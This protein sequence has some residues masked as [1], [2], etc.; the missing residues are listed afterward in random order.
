VPF[1]STPRRITV[2]VVD[3][4]YINILAVDYPNKNHRRWKPKTGQKL[5]AL[6][7]GAGVK[8]L[9]NQ[10]RS[11]PAAALTYEDVAYSAIKKSSSLQT[12]CKQLFADWGAILNTIAQAFESGG[13]KYSRE[14]TFHTQPLRKDSLPAGACARC[15]SELFFE[16]REKLQC[17]EC[18][19]YSAAPRKGKQS[20]QNER[21][22]LAAIL[23]SDDDTENLDA[24]VEEF[25]SQP[26][27]I[28]SNDEDSDPSTAQWGFQV[29]L[30]DL[31]FSKKGW[32]EFSTN[33]QRPSSR[34][35]TLRATW[36]ANR[37]RLFHVL[38]EQYPLVRDLN[39]R[40]RTSAAEMTE[41]TK[42]QYRAQMKSAGREIAS[43]YW[44]AFCGMTDVE[45]SKALSE[46]RS[47]QE[48]VTPAQVKN[49][50]ESFVGRGNTLYSVLEPLPASYKTKWLAF[51]GCYWAALR[52]KHLRS[53]GQVLKLW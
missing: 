12:D 34:R 32:G 21:T 53:C 45:I 8:D 46:Y 11:L 47:E 7:E 15:G 43:V 23:N 9:S 1:I 18:G 30:G 36:L 3:E 38:A 42:A 4:P 22:Q 44:F 37:E 24:R 25:L 26:A 31:I 41:Y 13:Q 52:T 33:T 40:L 10:S 19:K 27:G 51:K 28:A 2:P 35:A 49:I 14:H 5:A 16:K 20:F 6:I 50:R 17:F 48:T 29:S 39:G